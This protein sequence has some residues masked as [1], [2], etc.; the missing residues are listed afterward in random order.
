MKIHDI[1]NISSLLEN[2]AKHAEELE[3][4]GFWGK[5]GAG[6]FCYAKNTGKFLLLFRDSYVEQPHTWGL[7]G[8]AI[9]P[10]ED[11]KNAA[12]REL[13][14]E[15]SINADPSQLHLIYTFEDKDS[16]FKYYNYLCILEEEETPILNWENENYG[17]FSLDNLPKP[18]HFGVEKFI[19]NTSV[20]ET[21]RKIT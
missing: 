21:I 16:G 18:L 11:S 14:E 20:I 8:G 1:E 12:L 10:Q 13:I 19:H 6:C 2:D 5:R 15:T 9:D 3:K 4:T 7:A 17:W